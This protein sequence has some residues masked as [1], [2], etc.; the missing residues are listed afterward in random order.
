MEGATRRCGV[1]G[2][3]HP[4]R[5]LAEVAGTREG[6]TVAECPLVPPDAIVFDGATKAAF[7][8]GHG[9]N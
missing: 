3:R 6:L 2:A 9:S 5:R 4:V 7:S 8:I 1:C